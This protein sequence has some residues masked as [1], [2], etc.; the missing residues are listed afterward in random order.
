MSAQAPMTP[1]CS[2]P[3]QERPEV[4]GVGRA[5]CSD[6][7]GGDITNPRSTP[8]R[9]PTP[10]SGPHLDGRRLV[11][12]PRSDVSGHVNSPHVVVISPH[13]AGYVFGLVPVTD[14]HQNR[15]QSR[16]GHINDF[17]GAALRL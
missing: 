2:S 3:E 15:T 12:H 14:D 7:P 16:D 17:P 13:L 1:K 9:S 6:G 10:S 8:W 5:C 4:G 11:E